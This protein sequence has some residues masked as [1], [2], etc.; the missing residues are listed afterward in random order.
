MLDF[1]ITICSYVRFYVHLLE[2][3]FKDESNLFHCNVMLGQIFY[4]FIWSVVWITFW[5]SYFY[6]L[7]AF[8]VINSLCSPL[9]I[10][11]WLCREKT[12]SDYD[13]VKCFVSSKQFS[14]QFT[15]LGSDCG[16][17]WQQ[18]WSRSWCK[19]SWIW[20]WWNS[21][22]IQS[23]YIHYVPEVVLKKSALFFGLI[24]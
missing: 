9:L 17:S 2:W 8:I 12:F 6:H 13:I 19:N 23:R 11:S 24:A 20:M 18:D 22:C 4:I 21:A 15:C 10:K 7:D 5:L 14:T 1:C 3:F 16:R